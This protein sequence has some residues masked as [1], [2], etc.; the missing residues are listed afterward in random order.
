MPGSISLFN[1]NKGQTTTPTKKVVKNMII[2]L[3]RSKEIDK[4]NQFHNLNV[5]VCEGFVCKI[6]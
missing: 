6:R 4:A 1:A 2:I 5:Y 3:F